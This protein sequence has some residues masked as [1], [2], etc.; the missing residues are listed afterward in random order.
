[1]FLRK[2]KP[3]LELCG[4][5]YGANLA[6]QSS[7]MALMEGA[8]TPQDAREI[9]QTVLNLCTAFRKDVIS[10][11]DAF[12]F[13]DFI[14]MAPIGREDGDIYRSYFETVKRSN[15]VQKPPYFDREIKPLLTKL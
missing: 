3:A 9:H 1:M 7:D 4:L 12:G 8:I 2:L 15:P 6:R 10:F 14:I 11:V 13:P 5:L